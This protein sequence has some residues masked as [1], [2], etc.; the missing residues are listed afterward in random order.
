MKS[1][2]LT[3]KSQIVWGV[4]TRA[5]PGEDICGDLHLVK[6]SADSA[7]LAAVDGLGHG[8]EAVAAA[9]TALS[10][11]ES[12]ADQPLE[13]QVMRC[14]LALR[15]SRGVVMTVVKLSFADD[16]LDWLGV[17]N[18]E[19]LLLRHPSPFNHSVSRVFSHHG[20]VGYRLPPVMRAYSHPITPGSMLILATDGV[21]PNF[22]ED[23]APGES[24]Q[25]SANQILERYFRGSD[26]AL[27]LVMH[28]IAS[29]HD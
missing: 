1:N 8:T 29:S 7:L 6:V 23:V 20:I 18:V 10:V 2:V 5:A 22:A 19:A 28:Y 21:T 3:P 17:G 14:H 4:A 25:R 11:L 12:S 24:P 9:K 13:I 27:V 16:K 26:D 15:K